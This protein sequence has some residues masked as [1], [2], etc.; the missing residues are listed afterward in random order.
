MIPKIGEMW[1]NKLT[2]SIVHIEGIRFDS[3]GTHYVS[4]NGYSTGRSVELYIKTFLDNFDFFGVEDKRKHNKRNCDN[5]TKIE[6]LSKRLEQ[7]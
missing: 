3:A 4:Y 6:K 1:R 7:L 5:L 2:A